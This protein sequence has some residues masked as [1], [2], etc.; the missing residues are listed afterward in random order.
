M[1]AKLPH[2]TISDMQKLTTITREAVIELHN[3]SKIHVK[4]T[5]TLRTKRLGNS[6]VLRTTLNYDFSTRHPV[7]S[8]L[9]MQNWVRS[10]DMHTGITLF[11]N[12]RKVT[13][14]TLRTK[15]PGNSLV[16]RTTLN[17]DVQHKAHCFLFAQ[18]TN[19]SN[20]QYFER[21]LKH[22]PWNQSK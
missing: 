3:N 1:V 22:I 2:S 10:R 8:S 14:H 15:R 16:S 5:H 20:W 18:S 19:S 17:Y 4:C 9:N 6:F 7:L 21:T 13:T 11:Q 12:T